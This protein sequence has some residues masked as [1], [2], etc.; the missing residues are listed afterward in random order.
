[1][2][3]QIVLDVVKDFPG[4][5]PR[6]G[7]T[8]T[9]FPGHSWPV[10]LTRHLRVDAIPYLRQHLPRLRCRRQACERC[11]LACRAGLPPRRRG[12]RVLK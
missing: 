1:M 5:W 8:V 9:L 12:L 3:Q 4:G 11:P 6:A 10:A 7:D 2:A